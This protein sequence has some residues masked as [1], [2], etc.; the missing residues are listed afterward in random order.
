MDFSISKGFELKRSNR[1]ELKLAVKNVTRQQNVL[2]RIYFFDRKKMEIRKLDRYSMVP[3]INF[4]LR[5][6][7]Q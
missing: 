3:N 4:G 6:Y 7:H 2:E 1:L 5:F